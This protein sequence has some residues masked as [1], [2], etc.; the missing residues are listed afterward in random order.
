MLRLIVL[1]VLAFTALAPVAAFAFLRPLGM[2]ATPANTMAVDA[3]PYQVDDDGDGLYDE[4]PGGLSH[5]GE[6]VDA[7]GDTSIDEDN[8]GTA[9]DDVD[10]ERTIVGSG[11]FDASVNIAWGGADED[12]WNGYRAAL[13]Y[14]DSILEFVAT[15]DVTADGT[16]DSW[17]FTGLGRSVLDLSVVELDQDGDG[18]TDALRGGS[19]QTSGA[20]G[21]SG[22]A[23]V[24]RF[25]CVGSGSSPLHLITLVED[26]THGSATYDYDFQFLPTDLLDASITCSLNAPTPTPTSTP[27]P[28]VGG[29][30]ELPD[31]SGMPGEAAGSAAHGSRPFTVRYVATVG[32]VVA[33]TLAAAAGA[34]RLRAWRP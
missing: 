13:A 34:W 23:L 28:A 14:D 17:A 29:V 1:G 19:S 15:L 12:R 8:P 26:P 7:D 2:G 5:Q 27:P 16:L 30:A 3:L 10:A 31:M 33:A 18:K 6:R 20:T 22:Q 24:V 25:R 11:T 21:S 9:A 4:D 32:A